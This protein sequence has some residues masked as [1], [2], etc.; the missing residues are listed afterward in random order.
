MSTPPVQQNFGWVTSFYSREVLRS[1]IFVQRAGTRT[2]HKAPLP[3]AAG[4]V[5]ISDLISTVFVNLT[6]SFPTCPIRRV[7]IDSR[8]FTI[9]RFAI[10]T[11][12]GMLQHVA[13]KLEM[14][15]MVLVLEI[16]PQVKY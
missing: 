1:K 13:V 16:Y 8:M 12:L 3:K 2:L 5:K 4:L 7:G 15:V 9:I 10:T 14:D 11:R 6:L